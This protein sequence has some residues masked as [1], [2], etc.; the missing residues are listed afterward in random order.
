MSIPFSSKRSKV[1]SLALMLALCLAVPAV[2]A[3]FSARVIHKMQGRELRGQA[4]V[5]ADKVRQQMEIEGGAAVTILRPDKQL[6]WLLFPLQKTYLEMPFKPEEMGSLLTAPQDR[7][8]WKLLGAETLQGYDV[9]KYEISMTMSG[10][11]VKTFIWLSKKL[12]APLR[13]TTGDGSFTM[14]YLDIKEGGQDDALFE[15]PPGYQKMSLP[16]KM[17]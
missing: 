10:K 1:A 5:K 11:E 14:E 13:M 12:N 3:E 7:S 9:D 16:M 17:P 15:L 2:A 6:V 8:R 4:F